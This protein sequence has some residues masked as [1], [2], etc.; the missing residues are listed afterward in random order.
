[1]DLVNCTKALLLTS[2]WILELEVADACCRKTKCSFFCFSINLFN[3]Q[4]K[5]A[6]PCV[7]AVQQS[8]QAMREPR[9]K[10]LCAGALRPRIPSFFIVWNVSLQNGPLEPPLGAF[11]QSRGVILCRTGTVVALNAPN[12]ISPLGTHAPISAVATI[13][14]QPLW[15]GATG[16]HN[17]VSWFFMEAFGISNARVKL[18]FLAHNTAQIP[19][20]RQR[21]VALI[22]KFSTYSKNEFSFL[23][24]CSGLQNAVWT[25]AAYSLFSR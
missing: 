3:F 11:Y 20:T 6:N 8:K 24:Y 4:T 22:F 17:R 19:Q 13:D 5:Q 16:Q 15:W 1:M 14:E 7:A 23:S 12:D 21:N 18:T 10:G 9:R 25:A 2:I